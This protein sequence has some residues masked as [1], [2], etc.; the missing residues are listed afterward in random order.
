MNRERRCLALFIA[1]AVLFGGVDPGAVFG[2][3]APT[4][5]PTAPANLEARVATIL[6]AL[7]VEE[8]VGQLFM[9]NFVGQNAAPADAI[10]Q[11]ILTTKSAAL[12]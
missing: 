2:Q 10:A 11:L 7:T 3:V 4:P 8:R 6:N 12:C 1:L 5:E 9:V